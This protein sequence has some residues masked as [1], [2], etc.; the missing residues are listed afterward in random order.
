M[1]IEIVQISVQDKNKT[2]LKYVLP[3]STMRGIAAKIVQVESNTK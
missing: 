3:A 2:L 1:K